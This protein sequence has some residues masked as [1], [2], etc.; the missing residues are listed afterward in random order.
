VLLREKKMIRSRSTPIVPRPGLLPVLLL[1]G[2]LAGC[3]TVDLPFGKPGPLVETV[4]DGRG[5]A[6]ILLVEIDGIIRE[7]A[8]TVPFAMAP[9]EGMVARVRAQLEKAAGDEAVKALV[10][11]IHSPGGTATGSEILYGEILRFKERSGVPVVAELMGVATSGAYFTAMA[12]DSVLAHPTT[13]TGSIGVVF[14]GVNLSGLM[15]KIGLEDQTLKSGAYKDAGSPLRRMRPEEREQLQS[16]LDDLHGRFRQVVVRGRPALAAE[17]VAE[18]ADGRVYSA[19]Q[20][21]ENGLID[22]IADLPD[23]IVE[24]RRRAGL[25]EARVVSFHRRRD[26]RENI[27]TRPSGSALPLL[28]ITTLL[29]RLRSPAFLYLWSPGI[30]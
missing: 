27:Y 23:A 17:R 20:A 3:I 12:A 22:A 13:V 28:E 1:A 16:V 21:L 29:D 6:K 4:L 30:R 24:A 19:P 15:E 8:Q 5:S 25:D 26:W 18:L 11:R 9:S 10:L 14:A 7:D 2:L